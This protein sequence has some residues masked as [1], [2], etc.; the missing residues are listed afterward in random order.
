MTASALH[1]REPV[2]CHAGR[3][4][5]RRPAVAAGRRG[6]PA[7]AI[8]EAIPYRKRD[9]TRARD[10][11]MHGWFAAHGYAGIRARPARL[12]RQRGPARRRI[13]PSRSRTTSCAVI[14]WIGDAALVRRHGRH[15]RHLLGRLQRPAGRGAPPAGAEGDHH[16]L[17]DRRPLCRRR[18]F[19]GRGAA[20][21]QSVVG[22]G[23]DGLAGSAADALLYPAGWRGLWRERIEALPFFPAIWARHP[24]RD[25][26]WRH[27]SVCED[28]VRAS[29]CRSSPSA[30]GPTPMSAPSPACI[31]HL[32]GPRLGLIG[33]WAHHYPHQGRPGPA[34]GF[35]AEAMRWW[36]HWLKGVRHRHHGRADA[37]RLHAGARYRRV[38]GCS[39]R[40]VGEAS[41]PSRLIT[42]RPMFLSPGQLW[43][44]P[45]PPADLA[46]R[47][48]LWCGAT[49][50]TGCAPGVAG[51]APADQRL[52]DGLSLV[53]D[54]KELADRTEILGAP[55]LV[56]ELA[57]DSADGA[58]LRAALATSRR[59]ARR[60]ASPGR[61]STSTHRRGHAE[62]AALVPG[63]LRDGP[64][65]A[66][67]I[68]PMPSGRP[69]HPPCR[70]DLGLADRL[71]GAGPGD[72]DHPDRRQRPDSAR[73]PAA[74]RGCRDRASSRRPATPRRRCRSDR[75]PA[76]RGAASPSTSDGTA[77][78]AIEGDAFGEP[79]AVFEEIATDCAHR[80]RRDAS[81]RDGDA[82]QRA[83]GGPP[84]GHA[85]LRR[86]ALP[87]RGDGAR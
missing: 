33:P 80:I 3:R 20:Q 44:R 73:P 9:G 40:W 76:R 34:I 85:G 47:S 29:R 7:P 79:P 10:E 61:S 16:R 83:A 84:R 1:R 72:A 56:L 24:R 43:W 74:A 15:D 22:L 55:E 31:E 65:Q 57:S 42:R 68:A 23:H 38:G 70:L 27:G 36:D 77:S 82:E 60:P 32:P 75:W 37:A 14:A 4:S 45:A 87:H 81:I 59:T 52:D 18:A 62:P 12:G 69:P 26:Y 5:P 39:G 71:A 48:P 54:S 6:E 35:L 13:S 64:R 67:R 78:I 58:A 19:H 66:E 51:E 28:C 50:A 25:A 21:R 63:R 53:F 49:P 41:W 86:Q 30:A 11:A 2:H 8:L 17:L 46:I